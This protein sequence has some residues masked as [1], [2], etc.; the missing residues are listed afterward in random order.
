M[1]NDQPVVHQS[2]PQTQSKKDKDAIQDSKY[3][4]IYEELFLDPNLDKLSILYNI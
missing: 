1:G 3:H 2:K 4:K